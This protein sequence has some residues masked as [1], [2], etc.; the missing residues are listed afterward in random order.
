[1]TYRCT[2]VNCG[3]LVP[4]GCMHSCLNTQRTLLPVGQSPGQSPATTEVMAA[5]IAQKAAET[6]GDAATGYQRLIPEVSS[7]T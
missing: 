1:M 2:Q 4:D 6:T 5:S 3:A 7:L